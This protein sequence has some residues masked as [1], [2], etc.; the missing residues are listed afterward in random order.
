MGALINILIRTSNR[1]KLF[2]RCIESVFNQTY[3]NIRIIIAFDTYGATNYIN[4]LLVGK[5]NVDLLRVIPNVNYPYYWNLYCNHLKHEVKEGWFM[6]LDDD[7]VLAGP[8]VIENMERILHDDAHL[9]QFSRCG[10]VKPS[11]EYMDKRKIER[12]K[13]GMPCIVLHHSIKSAIQFDGDKGADYRF[14][15]SISEVVD[16][17]FNKLVLVS[18]DNHGL[19]GQM[20]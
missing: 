5:T 1:P 2:K 19:M 20:E 14:I 4:P 13:V 12:G 10:N 18:C 3:G 16:I 9:F 15:K 17:K 8:D 11:N 6:F 7:D